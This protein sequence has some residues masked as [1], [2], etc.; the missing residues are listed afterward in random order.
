MRAERLLLTGVFT[1]LSLAALDAGA[2][3]VCRCVNGEMK[4]IC[5]SSID[6][7]PICP[8][9][10]CPLVPPAVAPIQTPRVPPIGT[11]ECRQQQVL[12]PNANRYEWREV[13]K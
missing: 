1:T 6:L 7:P 13:C 8:P 9:T 4:P 5:E 12:N 3:C 10:V 2:A 11:K